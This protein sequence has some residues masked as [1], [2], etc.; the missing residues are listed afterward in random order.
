MINAGL[1]VLLAFLM[2]AETSGDRTMAMLVLAMITI[3]VLRRLVAAIFDPSPQH[4]QVAIKVM[5]LSLVMLDA[6]LVVFTTGDNVLGLM[7]AALLVPAFILAR[8]IPMT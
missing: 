1:A 7:T 8:W 2:H 4:V 5:L 3:T 6:L